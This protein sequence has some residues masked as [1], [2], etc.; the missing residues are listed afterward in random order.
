M[1]DFHKT[2]QENQENAFKNSLFKRGQKHL[3]KEIERK[4]YKKKKERN[5]VNEKIGALLTENETKD[6]KKGQHEKEFYLKGLEVLERIDSE[7]SS[8][9]N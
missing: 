3:L 8:K 9:Q 6:G 1:Y 7:M 5:E 2:R 4:D